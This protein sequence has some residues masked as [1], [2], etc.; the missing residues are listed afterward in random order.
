MQKIRSGNNTSYAYNY[1]E[2]IEKQRD[3]L[4]FM[5][6]DFMLEKKYF[7]GIEL[8]KYGVIFEIKRSGAAVYNSKLRPKM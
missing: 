4:S 1:K 5:I 8:K 6:H 2:M 7:N 3:T